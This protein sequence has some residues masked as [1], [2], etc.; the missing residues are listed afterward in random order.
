MY[1][2]INSSIW[3]YRTTNIDNMNMIITSYEITF[4]FHQY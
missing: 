3:I 2:G 4:K 1:Y